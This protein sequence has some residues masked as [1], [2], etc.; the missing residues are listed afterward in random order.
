MYNLEKINNLISQLRNKNLKITIHNIEDYIDI[1]QLISNILTDGSI[2][3]YVDENGL[4]EELDKIY[5]LINSINNESKIIKKKNFFLCNIF[6]FCYSYNNV[7][8]ETLNEIIKNLDKLKSRILNCEKIVIEIPKPIIIFKAEL[9]LIVNYTDINSRP[10]DY[11]DD[12]YGYGFNNKMFLEFEIPN[13]NVQNNLFKSVEITGTFH[14]QGFGGTGQSHIRIYVNKKIKEIFYYKRELNDLNYKIIL[15][16]VKKGYIIS[17]W[18][19]TP[20]W[21]G[22]S[23]NITNV[24]VNLYFVE[25]NNSIII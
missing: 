13:L 22:W 10:T 17:A 5:E 2:E 3:Y 18:A 12:A 6:T 15:N 21:N 14:D 9:P 8:Y 24:S 20:E 19:C 16:N 7:K 25:N 23:I 11:K 4:E 1:L